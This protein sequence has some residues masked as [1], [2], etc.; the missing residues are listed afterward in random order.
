M[1][2]STAVN[3]VKMEGTRIYNRARQE[4]LPCEPILGPMRHCTPFACFSRSVRIFPLFLTQAGNQCTCL[5][6]PAFDRGLSPTARGSIASRT[7]A[8][9]PGAEITQQLKSGPQDKSKLLWNRNMST[10]L[11]NVLG[12]IGHVDCISVCVTFSSDTSAKKSP[13][14]PSERI[15]PLLAPARPPGRPAF[16]PIGLW[17]VFCPI[18]V[19]CSCLV[20]LTLLKAYFEHFPDGAATTTSLQSSPLISGSP[21]AAGESTSINGVKAVGGA[22]RSPK[23]SKYGAAGYVPAGSPELAPKV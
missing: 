22:R 4:C 17:P 2:K 20:Y 9:V 10:L 13:Q 23:M 15:M 6:T 8:H 7:W 5:S 11:D 1:S 19:E 16:P 18:A 12:R 3:S 21:G 14:N